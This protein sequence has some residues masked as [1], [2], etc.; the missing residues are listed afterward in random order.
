MAERMNGKA[1]FK[2][3]NHGSERRGVFPVPDFNFGSR[4]EQSRQDKLRLLSLIRER[5]EQ[6][7]AQP[8]RSD[9]GNKELPVYN[10]KQELL[11][12]IEEFKCVALGGETGSGKSTQLP[13]YLYEAGYDMTIVLVPRRVIANGL[14]DRIREELSGQIEDF[15]P[16]ETVGI[17]HGERSERHENNKIMVMTPNTYLKMESD[18][19]SL[20]G[21]KKVA[22]VADEIHEANLFTEIAV[23]SAALA[24]QDNEQWRLIAASATHNME[25]LRKPFQK[26]NGGFMP[27]VEVEG[28]PFEVEMREDAERNSMQVYADPENDHKVSMI[29]TSGKKEIEHIKDETIL[30]LEKTQPGSSKNVI[31]RYLH[32]DLTEVELSHIN[33]PI[34][35][36]YRLVIISSPAGMSGITI[37]QATLV[38][39]DGTINR[40]ELD[41]EGAS[42]LRRHYLSKAG[43]K[44]QIGRAGRD[45]PGGV[46]ILARPTTVSED[47]IR[48]RGGQAG[49]PM[50]TFTPYADRAD[51]EPPE[52]YSTNLSRVVLTVASL[53]R[54]F[55]EINEY[56]PHPVEAS[57]II[58]AEEALSRLGALDDDDKITEVGRAMDKFPVIPELARGLYEAG[59]PGRS[60]QHMARA[61]FIAASV[62]VGGLQDYRDK[63]QTEWK[64]LIRSTTAD[65]FI[66]QLDLMSAVDDAMKKEQPD[67]YF[68][69]TYTL[70]PKRVEH[71]RKAARKI[72]KIMRI[73]IDNMSVLPPLPNE[74][75]DLRTDF[76]SGM[77]DLTYEQ[78]GQAVRSRKPMYRNIHG[79]ADSTQRTVSDRSTST[80]KK[81]QLIAGIP[82]W[83]EKENKRDNTMLHFDIID[84]VL[85]V[86]PKTVGRFAMQNSLLAGQLVDSRLDGDR[87]VEY[88]QMKFGSLPV[89]EP[90]KSTW[91]ESIPEKTQQLLVRRSLE[92]PGDAHRALRD[93]ADELA[94]Y[95]E[96]FPEDILVQYRKTDAPKDITK[97][98]IVELVTEL[99]Q[100]TRSLTDIDRRIAQHLFS[101]NASISKYY[102]DEAR[103]FLQESA[104][105]YIDLAGSPAQVNYANGTPYLTNLTKA[106][107][108]S[109]RGALHLPD[110]REIYIQASLAKG[111]T[112]RVSGTVYRGF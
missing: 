9:L 40:S 85:I 49:E 76:T 7:D 6:V 104:P 74:E 37:P 17:I 111:G 28:R 59:R 86:D 44:Q 80:L 18:L 20:F 95:K 81:G 65:D 3:R 82:R 36:D 8:E 47:K 73:D 57:E 79:N 105:D 83:Y 10:H 1:P 21:D 67:T 66:A 15:V 60:L 4:Q 107:K 99:A 108:Q 33:D 103:A 5:N 100:T 43:I 46:G 68:A 58:K 90:V 50:M 75:S 53:D 39:T 54:R 94:I 38:I 19:R 11:A 14:G 88:E 87:A 42:G 35:E 23:G 84:Q 32:G 78:V 102:D 29:F 2:R 63:K 31:F 71:A 110:G 22:I 56:I 98:S 52:I 97:N 64:K 13:Q 112:E 109:I 45:V 72:L 27:I 77:I 91:R 34:P 62:D 41:D 101:S 30:E 93:I 16:E 61:A 51:H 55:A 70:H 92:S 24:V 69:E 89:G 106:Q 12:N 26:I 48:R 25:T 96:R